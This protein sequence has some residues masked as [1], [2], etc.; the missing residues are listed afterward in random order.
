MYGARVRSESPHGVHAKGVSFAHGTFGVA[1]LLAGA[2]ALLAGC[3]SGSRAPGQSARELTLE[4]SQ[5]EQVAN[6][7]STLQR[8]VKREVAASRAAWP[9]IADGLPPTLPDSLRTAVSATSTSAKALPEPGFLANSSRLTGPAAG[10]AGIYENYEQLAQ[11]GWTMT[12]AAVQTIANATANRGAAANQSATANG[13]ATAH[14]RATAQAS[15]ERAN[16][17]LYIDA[18]YDAHFDLSLLGKSL[19]SGYEKLGGVQAFGAALTQSQINALAAAYSIPAVR[20][21][22]HPAGAAKDG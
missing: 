19:L 5:F 3:G 6:E 10:L 15:F 14:A 22:P 8:A 20:L 11:R 4:R 21:E 16:S 7:L 13:N 12:N 1:I 9:S 17:P 18:S 2:V